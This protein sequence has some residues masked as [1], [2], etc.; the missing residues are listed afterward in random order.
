MCLWGQ[1]GWVVSGGRRLALCVNVGGGNHGVAVIAR[2]LCIFLFTHNLYVWGS[3][4]QATVRR[5]GV[6]LLVE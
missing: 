6:G 3:L 5:G 1:Q 4:W 2:R